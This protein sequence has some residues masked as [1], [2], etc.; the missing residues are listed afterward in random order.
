MSK[1]LLIAALGGVLAYAV[2]RKPKKATASVRAATGP[3]AVLESGFGYSGMLALHVRWEILQRGTA[4]GWSWKAS[5]PQAAMLSGVPVADARGNYAS[6][7]EASMALDEALELQ[8]LPPPPPPVGPDAGPGPRRPPEGPG[9]FG[10]P[11]PPGPKAPPLHAVELYPPTGDANKLPP[12]VRSD[13]MVISDDGA[14][15]GIGVDFWDR[16]GDRVEELEGNGQRDENTLMQMLAEEFF[17]V[18]E[19]HLYPAP[20]RIYSEMVDRVR[21]YLA[22][23]S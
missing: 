6:S 23:T 20:A 15:A 14:V 18:E 1:A 17:P 4:Y 16:V 12:L 2:T 3:D 19:I 21:S 8:P 13:G 5:D 7:E 9:G 10:A 22:S 11:Q